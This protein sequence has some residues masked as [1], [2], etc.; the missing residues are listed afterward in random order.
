MDGRFRS[1]C[2]F[3]SRASSAFMDRY[4]PTSV[5][6]LDATIPAL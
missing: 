6:E 2:I 4:D 1:A 3:D 5:A